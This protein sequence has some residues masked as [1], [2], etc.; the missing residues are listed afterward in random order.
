MIKLQDFA[1]MQG[2]SDRQINRL[3]QKY[4]AELE[5]LFER[6][7]HNGTWLTDEACKILRSKMKSAPVVVADTTAQDEIDELR[8]QLAEANA[9]F[10]RY[11]VDSTAMLMRASEQIALAERAGSLEAR[12]A[13]LSAELSQAR[14]IASQAQERA[15][16]AAS[17]LTEAQRRITELEG[18]KWY[19]LLFKKG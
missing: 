3:L 16:A 7:G 18:R 1:A 8:R 9:A 4:A 17:E 5:G 13:D 12:N 11:V 10:Q 2:V 19:H 6:R 15:Q 14:E